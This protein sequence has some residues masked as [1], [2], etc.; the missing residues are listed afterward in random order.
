MIYVDVVVAL[1]KGVSVIP[2]LLW[3]TGSGVFKAVC[4]FGVNVKRHEEG[5][6]SSMSIIYLHITLFMQK[7]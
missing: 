7:C 3:V 2:G 4:L 1:L 6:K 5:K